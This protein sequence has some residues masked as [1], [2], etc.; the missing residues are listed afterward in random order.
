MTKRVCGNAQLSQNLSN[1]FLIPDKKEVPG[2]TKRK[3]QGGQKGS[4]RSGKSG[5]LG[6]SRSANIVE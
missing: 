2:K 4:V 3:C 5:C 1:T 6:A